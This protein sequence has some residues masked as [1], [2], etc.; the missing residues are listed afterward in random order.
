MSIKEDF[1]NKDYYVQN[2][3]SLNKRYYEIYL[4]RYNAKSP[5]RSEQTTIHTISI[6]AKDLH[7]KSIYPFV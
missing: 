6:S 7:K 2:S 5:L 1:K 4:R 3:V